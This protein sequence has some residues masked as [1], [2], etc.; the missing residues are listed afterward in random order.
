[1]LIGISTQINKSEARGRVRFSGAG[2]L[3]GAH[4]TGNVLSREQIRSCL[5]AQN[6]INSEGDRIDFS[7]QNLKIKQAE[8]TNLETEIA[9]NKLKIDIYSQE[10]VDSFNGQVLKYKALVASYNKS[11]S[12]H[13][14]IVQHYES[15][16]Q[17]FTKDCVGRSYYE[18]DMKEV[19]NEN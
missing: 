12:V 3:R 4:H 6:A 8:L 18:N 14:S 5:A 1:M 10:S 16:L 7:V 13:N 17:A 2:L 9:F 19:L 11:A 15:Q